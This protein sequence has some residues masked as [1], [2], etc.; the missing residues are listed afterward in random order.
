MKRIYSPEE[1]KAIEDLIEGC[2]E[3]CDRYDTCPL[4]KRI[5]ERLTEWYEAEEK[6]TLVNDATELRKMI[7]ENPDLPIMV[8]AGSNTHC[9][10]YIYTACSDVKTEIGE[11][12]DCEQKVNEEKIYCDRMD[13]EDDL[14][15]RLED[16]FDGPNEEFD[17]YVEKESKKY[18][19]HWKKAIIVYADN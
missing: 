8:F 7:I 1:A 6:K 18:D 17:A 13:F 9:D 15:S 4:C 12:L 5:S 11:V 19:Q 16:E 14:R 10:D 3:K 2:R